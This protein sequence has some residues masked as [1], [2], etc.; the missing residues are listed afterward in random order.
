MSSTEVIKQSEWEIYRGSLEQSDGLALFLGKR[1]DEKLLGVQ[2][3]LSK[4]RAAGFEGVQSAGD[5]LACPRTHANAAALRRAVSWLQPRPLGLMTSAGVGD[6][7]GLATPGHIHAARKALAA[8]PGAELGMIFAQQSIRE[9]TRTGRSPDNVMDDATW[10]IFQEGWRDGVGADAD[11]LKNTEDIDSCLAA[12][13]SFYTIDPGDHVDPEADSRRRRC[14]ASVRRSAVAVAG[15]RREAMLKAYAGRSWDLEGR[16]LSIDEESLVRAAVKYGR[17]VAHTA[18]MYRHLEQHAPAGGWELEVSVDETET[19][20]THAEH[21]FIATE[22]KRLGVRWV[23][24]AP[25]YVGRF[26]KGVDYIGDL[27]AFRRTSPGTPRSR[28]PSGRTSSASTPGPTSSASTGSR[29]STRT[30]CF[31]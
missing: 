16:R 14:S 22:L 7:L 28:V 15:H 12:G 18:A 25:R 17:A 5:L 11:H 8:A 3:D 10:G 13:F 29:R 30:G 26:E 27:D 24:L 1:G 31:T 21:L 19:P 23:S 9:M 2:G 20:T 4:A 6:R